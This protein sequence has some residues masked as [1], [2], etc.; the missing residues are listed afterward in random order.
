MYYKENTK[1][2]V[3]IV[4]YMSGVQRRALI[5][6]YFYECPAALKQLDNISELRII[7]SL[8][9]LR[10]TLFLKFKKTDDLMKYDLKNL[11]SISWFSYQDIKELEENGIPILKV[12]YRSSKYMSDFNRLIQEHINSCKN[13]F[14][15]WLNWDYIKDLFV[16]P[17]GQVESVVIKEFNKYME[18]LGNYPYQ[19][20]LHWKPYDCGNMLFNDKKFVSIIYDLNDDFFNENEKVTDAADYTKTNIYD[21]IQRNESTAIVVDCE[22]S[23][24]YKLYAMLKNLNQEELSKIRKIILFDDYHT[25]SA[26]DRLEKF[27]S[28]PVEHIEVERV[29]DNK[30]LVDIKMTAGVCREF[31]DNK[32]TSFILASSDSDYWGLISSLPNADFLVMY[33]YNKCGSAIKQALDTRGIYYC[34]IDDFCSGN[35]EVFKNSVLLDLLKSRINEIPDINGRDLVDEIY[36]SARL[37]AGDTEKNQYF[38]RYIKTLRLSVDLNGVFTIHIKE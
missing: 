29:V 14:P 7:R 38:E 21:F 15:A 3:S 8:C 4:A 23:N 30:S 19:V 24:V 25:T 18:N 33:E 17:K 28:I 34:S 22:N 2:I 31:Y 10:T 1:D 37:E 16:I 5:E 11:N 6:N 35:I 36:Q 12:N 13:F 9:K 20:Y 26:W 27:T 32:I